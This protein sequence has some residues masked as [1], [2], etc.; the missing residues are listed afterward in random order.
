MD[1][2]DRSAPVDELA[3][4]DGLRQLARR[5]VR[6]DA[7]ADDLVQESL[8]LAIR[9]EPG[10]VANWGA[11]L[12]GVVRKKAKQLRRA[13]RCRVAHEVAAADRAI[14]TASNPLDLAANVDIGERLRAA[15]NALPDSYRDAVWMRYVEGVE[16]PE[17]AQRLRQPVESVR[18]RI[19][20]GIHLVRQKLDRQHLGGR[21][22]WVAAVAEFARVEPTIAAAALSAS[23][24]AAAPL[25]RS[26]ALLGSALLV[27]GV[28][29]IGGIVWSRSGESTILAPVAE[30]AGGDP[31]LHQATPA[32]VDGSEA[33]TERDPSS[34]PPSDRPG[35]SPASA[36]VLRVDH[37]LPS[38]ATPAA[39]ADGSFAFQYR[40]GY[41]FATHS[42][43]DDL[44]DAD[45]VFTRCGG[46]GSTVTLEAPGGNI[47]SLGSFWSELP[48]LSSAKNLLESL[49]SADAAIA[50]RWSTS[51]RTD[52]R[53]IS[54]E[55]FVARTRG[56]A[57]I[58]F[59][60]VAREEKGEHDDPM[61][62]I[63][64]R[65][66]GEQPKFRDSN[67]ASDVV[68][69]GITVDRSLL[70]GLERESK[71]G[72]E[73]VRRAHRERVLARLSE[74]DR[75]AAT[76]EQRARARGLE[77][78]RCA[79]V[80]ARSFAEPMGGDE[81]FAA[82][83]Y[84]FKRGMRRNVGRDLYVDFT[85][86]MPQG[87][88]PKIRVDV[89]TDDRGAIV[90]LGC[91]DLLAAREIDRVQDVAAPQVVGVVGHSFLIHNLDSAT[92][93]WALMHVEEIT[94]NES[95][96]FWWLL[97]NDPGTLRKAM[98]P[99]GPEMSTPIARLQLRGGA[100]GGNPNR[101]FLNGDVNP[102]VD[103]RSTIPLDLAKPLA[104]GERHVAYVEGGY[105]PEGVV[106]LVEQV[107]YSALIQGDS[108][109]HGEALVS[110]RG[111]PV[112]HVEENREAQPPGS[113][114]R[115]F[116]LDGGREWMAPE[117]LP[118]RGHVAFQNFQLAIRR[119]EEQDVYV[120]IAN[121]SWVE[122]TLRGRFI[123][124][125]EAH[126]C[127]ARSDIYDYM[128]REIADAADD[129]TA[130]ESCAAFQ[131]SMAPMVETVLAA[132]TRGAWRRRL[133]AVLQ[134]L[135]Q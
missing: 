14:E 21:E 37:R 11:W 7:A 33:P 83:A 121:S 77:G 12:R 85:F 10:E 106:W 71:E 35:V 119:G 76:L 125:T 38:S 28:I 61:L 6:D 109:G 22:A 54:S 34:R 16:A 100:G 127:P 92:D 66:R 18:T 130:A 30:V 46:R 27:T 1:S 94:A 51:A 132:G 113:S 72:P 32:T 9:R 17:M 123:S 20:R 135:R 29:V 69:D 75:R 8:L 39:D 47:Q 87:A 90:D 60:I 36:A 64:Y 116:T 108:N 45:L 23:L 114:F 57:W 43:V 15:V 91:V 93:Q 128:L 86:D 79:A 25:G 102:Y 63:E 134:R 112:V 95:M 124:E 84:S 41:S 62:E 129:A 110:V 26:F 52:D 68:V 89:C 40:Q 82:S 115:S 126:P 49:V 24:V 2:D 70:D 44:G 59:A 131:P 133:E 81:A 104:I 105:V 120:E 78:I 42:T 103:E 58:A 97:L 73:R 13:E 99:P 88:E 4:T 117:Q 80:I 56:G 67:G 55:A 96:I 19:K 50:K 111:F 3:T 53:R 5:L 122:A 101:L 65:I 118:V 48:D 107:E 98:R 31:A 74:L